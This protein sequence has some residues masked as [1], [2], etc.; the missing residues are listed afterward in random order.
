MFRYT[1]ACFCFSSVFLVCQNASSD[2]VNL[3][4]YGD[5]EA[6]SIDGTVDMD[7]TASCGTATPY[8][9]S[10]TTTTTTTTT[11]TSS[12]TNLFTVISRLYFTS[13]EYIYLKF[14][15]DS[16]QNQGSIDSTQGFSYSG[17]IGTKAVV[18]NYGKIYW[19]GSGVPVDTSVT[20]SQALS[21][22]TVTLDLVGTAVASGS[23]ALALTQCYTVDFIN[24]TSATSTSMCY[25]QDGSTCYNTQSVTGPSVSIQGEVNCTSNTVS[26]GSSS[27][28]STTQ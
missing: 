13:G 14:L 24:C 3:T 6:F 22:L 27:S 2:K 26:S 18:A 10:S 12:S 1:L 11:S 19:G 28:S 4:V 15:Y 21:Y 16:T 17:G 7:K 8:S 5:G 25:T 9:S 23:T 20:S